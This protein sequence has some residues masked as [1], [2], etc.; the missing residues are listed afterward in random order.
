MTMEIMKS[1][2]NLVFIDAA[3]DDYEVLVQGLRPDVQTITI[4][5]EENG[6]DV[7]TQTLSNVD[8]KSVV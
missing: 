3:V 2:Q 4:H 5:P 8:R 7:I 6:I 1:T